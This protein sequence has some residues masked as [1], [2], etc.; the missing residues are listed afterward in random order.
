MASLPARI[1]YSIEEYLE[2]ESQSET[3]NEYHNGEIY[4]MARQGCASI[5]H[6][7]ILSNLIFLI[8]NS[9]KDKP[10]KVYPSDLRLQLIKSKLFTYPDAMIICG[11]PEFYQ[12]RKDTVTNPTVIFEILSESTE[13]YDRGEKFSFYRELPELKEYVLISSLTKKVEKFKFI[14]NGEWIF[15]ESKENEDFFLEVTKDSISVNDLYDK[16]DWALLEDKK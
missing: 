6:N 11:E 1:Y 7:E 14:G 4:A 15:K 5:F 12:N 3:K 10:C 2:L 13:K 9:L 16:I 8:K